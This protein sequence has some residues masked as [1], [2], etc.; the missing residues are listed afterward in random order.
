MDHILL[1][2]HLSG[3][4]EEMHEVARPMGTPRGVWWNKQRQCFM[5]PV[6]RPDG[7]SGVKSV[8]TLEECSTI[9][10]DASMGA[11]AD[12]DDSGQPE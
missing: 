10:E 12:L 7:A 9:L 6:L 11:I 2:I 5:V 3:F 8:N 1:F 4:D